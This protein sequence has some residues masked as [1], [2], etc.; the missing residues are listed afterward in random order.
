MECRC[1]EMRGVR[2]T[3]G[4]KKCTSERLFG[5]ET[6]A[7][8]PNMRSTNARVAKARMVNVLLP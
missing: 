3:W 1:I 5:I 8:Q 2:K 4:G 6:R 7:P